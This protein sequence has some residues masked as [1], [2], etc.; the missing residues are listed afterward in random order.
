MSRCIFPIFAAVAIAFANAA[1]SARA[2]SP[3]ASPSGRVDFTRDISPILSGRC[4]ACHG[5]DDAHRKA[6]LRLDV[7]EDALKSREGKAAIVPGS[8]SKSEL[9]RRIST[10]KSVDVMPPPKKG[11]KPL[12]PQET[13]LLKKWIEQG[14]P[15]AEHWAFVPPVRPPVPIVSN[16]YSVFSV[17]SGSG[18]TGSSKLNTDSLKTDHSNPI[19]AFISTKLAAEKLRPSPPADKTTLIRRLSL[20]LIGLPPTPEEVDAFLADKSPDAWSKQVERLLASPHY[21]ERWGRLWLDAA[22]YADSDGYEKDKRRLVHFYRDYVINAFNRDLPYDRFIIEQL[23]GDE[24]PNATQDQLV[25]TGFLRNSMLNEEGG[26]HPEQFRMEAMFDRMDAV[27]KGILGIT[28]LCAQCHNHKY[29]PLTQEEYYRMFAFLNNDHEAMPRVFTPSEQEKIASLRRE[30][31]TIEAAMR[32]QLPDWQSRMAKW[33]SGVARNQPEWTILRDLELISDNAQRYY[34]QADGSLLAAGWAPTKF[35][36]IFQTTNKLETLSAIRLELFTDPNLPANGPGRSHKG[37]FALTE[38][39]VE[40]APLSNPKKKTKVKFASATADFDQLELTLESNFQDGSTNRRVTGPIGFA[41]DGNKS[42]AWGGDSGPGRRNTDRVAVF[43]LA[44][45]ISFP[46]GTVLT[47]SLSQEHGSANAN[48]FGTQNLG[49]FRISA[50]GQASGQP[51]MVADR[52]PKKVREAFA[53]PAVRRTPEQVAAVFDHWRTMVPE[54]AAANA[55]LDALWQQWPEGTTAYALVA[56]TEERMTSVLNRGDWLKPTRGVKPGVPAFLN[57]LPAGADASRLTFARWIVDRRSPTTARVF[58]N[59]V[60]QAYFGTG[61]VETSEDFGRQSAKP[62]HPEL[63]DWLACEFMEG[64]GAGSGVS[65][66]GS[67]GRSEASQTSERKPQTL[68]ARPYPLRAEPWSVKN[69]HRLIVHSAT[70]QQSSRV[71]PESLTKDPY[72]RLLAR[73]P[74]FRVDAEIVRDV[75]LAASGLLNPK[76]GGRSVM[77]PAPEF[78]FKPPASYGDFPW[79]SETG[80]ERYRRAVYT[81]RRRSTPFPALLVF[82]APVGDFSCVRR[83]RSNTPLQALT[84]LNEPMFME[85][86]QALALHT[87]R[88]GGAS[89]TDK[90]TFAFR[91]CTARVPTKDEQK[92]LL[93][94]LTKQ[95]QRFTGRDADAWQ[96][97]AADPKNPPALPAAATPAKLAAWTAVSRVLLNLDETITKE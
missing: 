38:F 91:R 79:V 50:I 86:A 24:L 80:D 16:Q 71:T 2:A 8:L 68:D 5:P 78:L 1:T 59:R 76:V 15:Y 84:T 42:T 47:L 9:W 89:D 72:N 87:L 81:F 20:D 23:A 54:F 12:T 94:L 95:E 74:R 57:A 21:G 97:A 4:F 6:K 48:D 7:R 19:D 62:S 25:A 58:V 32:R 10:A 49:R 67:R 36:A 43:Q 37:L 46:G 30:I 83:Q 51:P 63:L 55:K 41:I 35:T 66:L 27:G 11:G 52:V 45:N 56:R 33:E 64:G 85:A 28:T 34:P 65:G 73:G 75:A 40:A 39:T 70:Y 53:V 60:W 31:G 96:L 22:R 88:D 77:P 93:S 44:T 82:D 29:D 69:L 3:T 90:I 18:R 14:A 92:E 26:V 17:L 13:A 61:L